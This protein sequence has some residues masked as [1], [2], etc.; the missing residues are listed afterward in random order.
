MFRMFLIVALVAALLPVLP[1]T[2]QSP[3]SNPWPPPLDA[4]LTGAQVSGAL[5]A[6]CLPQP[7]LTPAWNGDL[8]IFAHGYVAPEPYGSLEDVLKQLILPDGSTMPQLITGIG[9]AFAMT[10]Y[11]KN[12]LAVREGLA[13]VVD[14]ADVFTQRTGLTPKHVYLLGVSEGGL[15]TTLAA[16]KYPQ[17][18][19][20]GLALCGPIG[21]FRSQLNYWGDFR[22]LFDYFY[23]GA[24]PPS[25]IAIPP[26]VMFQWNTV[27]TPTIISRMMNPLNQHVTEQLLKTS[28]ASIDPAN[29]GSTAIETTVGILSYNVFATNEGKVELGGQPFDNKLKWYT[30]SDNDRKLNGSN[31]VQRFKAQLPLTALMDISRNYQTSGKLK[32]PLVTMHTLGDPIVPYWHETLYNAKALFGGSILKHLN[33]PINRYGHCTFTT[34]EALAGFAIL[35]YMVTGQLPT[36]PPGLTPAAQ[37]NYGSLIEKTRNQLPMP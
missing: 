8:V 37:K 31:G 30:G 4:C 20:G 33:I 15:I 6:I 26:E 35:N 13:D 24:L 29:P 5:Y 12:G 7:P 18:F 28:R 14:L 17:T 16:E 34:E 27:Y 11:S 36:T 25:P 9:Y 19:S 23:P 22:V 10:T 1:A 21:D 2:A 3:A 32:I